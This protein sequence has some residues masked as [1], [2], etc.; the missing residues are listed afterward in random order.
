MLRRL[1]VVVVLGLVGCAHQS[2][3]M[4]LIWTNNRLP[5]LQKGIDRTALSQA[6]VRLEFVDER[7]EP[8]DL[9]GIRNGTGEEF[10]TF[11]QVLPWFGQHFEESL[12]QYGVQVVRS[13]ETVR[14]RVTL[15]HLLVIEGGD[16]VAQLQGRVEVLS[17]AGGPPVATFRLKGKSEP[18][19]KTD[20]GRMVSHAASKAVLDAAHNLLDDPEFVLALRLPPRQ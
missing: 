12:V 18:R 14:V 17:P 8:R 20:D 11:T 13:E 7:P 2:S 4:M 3:P 1:A 6:R 10:R 5:G 9:V 19:G 16:Y 15:S